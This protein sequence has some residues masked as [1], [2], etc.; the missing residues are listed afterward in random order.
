MQA[1]LNRFR[2]I[3]TLD[4]GANENLWFHVFYVMDAAT[5]VERIGATGSLRIFLSTEPWPAV[6]FDLS[7]GRTSWPGHTRA[8]EEPPPARSRW[9]HSAQWIG[10]VQELI[11]DLQRSLCPPIEIGPKNVG[12][13]FKNCGELYR[14]SFD[15]AALRA[16]FHKT[17]DDERFQL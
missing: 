8:R 16:R 5:R 13:V 9:R 2:D 10:L 4:G 6:H 17:A 11:E 3:L 7:I 14:C 12:P 15:C 1:Q